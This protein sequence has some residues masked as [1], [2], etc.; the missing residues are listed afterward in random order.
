MNPAISTLLASLAVAGLSLAQGFADPNEGARLT[1]A[2]DGTCTLG[3]WGRAGAS[4]FVQESDDLTNWKYLPVIEPG[5]DALLEIHFQSP[6]NRLFLRLRCT[7]FPTNDPLAA[8]FDSD[9]LS[10]EAE[11]QYGTDPFTNDAGLDF[12][13]DGL[14]NAEEYRL[15]TKLREAADTGPAGAAGV[16][17]VLHT[18]IN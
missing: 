12:D 4:Y 3:W 1:R 9:G 7:D 5:L 13:A 11:V 2:S 14:T 18:D 8:D 16:A 15:G 10:N 6:A 17:L